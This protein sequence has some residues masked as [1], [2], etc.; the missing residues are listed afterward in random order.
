MGAS[1]RH[2]P[3][4]VPHRTCGAGPVAVLRFERY[5]PRPPTTPRSCAKQPLSPS[6]CRRAFLHI[7]SASRLAFLILLLP[8]LTYVSSRR[9][10]PFPTLSP[11]PP[12]LSPPPFF[13]PRAPFSPPG[14]FFT[15]KLPSV[16]LRAAGGVCFVPLSPE[17]L[18]T[19]P[20]YPPVTPND[21]TPRRTET[22][23]S[24]VR[25]PSTCSLEER[26]MLC[27]SWLG[28]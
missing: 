13:A 28:L 19:G 25:R 18:D 23:T 22:A 10:P 15:S 12:L 26:L 4:E 27:R 2:N 16:G 14:A 17:H 5:L 7:G 20:H 9:L 1:W 21:P 8:A 11:S 24:H 6:S 3:P